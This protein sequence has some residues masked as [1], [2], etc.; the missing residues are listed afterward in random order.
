M[1]SVLAE[2][3]WAI[4]TN[5]IN[6]RTIGGDTLLHKVI[7]NFEAVNLLLDAGVSIDRN[8]DGNTPLHVAMWYASPD[9]V[10]LVLMYDT[11]QATA[12]NTDGRTPLALGASGGR[13]DNIEVLYEYNTIIHNQDDRVLH[14]AVL[15][16][17]CNT[18]EYFLKR[19]VS[20]ETKDYKGR[21]PLQLAVELCKYNKNFPAIVDLILK[22]KSTVTK[23]AR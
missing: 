23:R 2:V 17:D 3:R 19:G 6:I 1:A 7:T 21:T 18:V 14:G 8:R 11:S 16:Q 5:N 4:Q 22:Y 13:L 15:S 10:R 20:T 9:I 12:L